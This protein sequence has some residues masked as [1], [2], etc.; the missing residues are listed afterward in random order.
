MRGQ[1]KAQGRLSA[2]GP[3]LSE[4]K[5]ETES[6]PMA[7]RPDQGAAQTRVSAALPEPLTAR[8]RLPNGQRPGLPHP[9]EREP[10]SVLGSRVT[11]TS[12]RV[13]TP[14]R[15]PKAAV[16]RGAPPALAAL[17]A[18]RPSSLLTAGLPHD[19]IREGEVPPRSPKLGPLGAPVGSGGS[20]D[21]KGSLLP[22]CARVTGEHSSGILFA[23]R[24][25]RVF[26]WDS[27]L[28]SK[29]FWRVGYKRLKFTFSV[30]RLY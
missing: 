8:P 6:V 14:A 4:G 9:E 23:G 19:R 26:R 29:A 27:V 2:R 20:A 3:V 25:Q 11:A 13:R 30:F 7:G 15:G 24:R 1:A 5:L 10:P 18:R 22:G 17:P 12:R 28:F 16:E 21:V